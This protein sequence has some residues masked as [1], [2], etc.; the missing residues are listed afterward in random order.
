MAIQVWTD[1][2]YIETTG[3]SVGFLVRFD[4]V[5]RGTERYAL[6][7]LPA[8]TNQSNEPRLHG[9]CGTYNDIETHACG[10][11]R[12]SRVAGNGRVLLVPVE[13]TAELLESMGYPELAG[14]I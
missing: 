3:A 7:L 12:V 5:L 2:D 9:W 6:R 13:A 1:S 8:H 10:L 4:N 14:E 11:A